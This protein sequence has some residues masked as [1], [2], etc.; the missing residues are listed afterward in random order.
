MSPRTQKWIRIGFAG[1]GAVIIALV[2]MAGMTL[3]LPRG[4]AGIDNL[5][6]PLVLVPLIWA[7]LFFHAC[8][9]R[10]LGRVAIV[11]I[12][13]FVLHA[14][15]LSQKFLDRPPNTSPAT[16]TPATASESSQ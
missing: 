14:G 3:W 10:R 16:A 12:G 8:L 11:A 15:L 4:A 5:V 2:V 7:S 9:D 1:P 6:V 13:L